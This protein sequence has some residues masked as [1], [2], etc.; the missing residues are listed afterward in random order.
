MADN[1]EAL[2]TAPEID[3]MPEGP[4]AVILVRPQLG[5]NIGMC[6]RAMMNC[7]LSDLRIVDPRDGW[8]N[9][10]ANAAAS[11]ADAIIDNA[12]IFETTE[13]AVA[14]LQF[15]LATTARARDSAQAVYTPREAAPELHRRHQDGVLCG[16]I[17]GPES[18]GL[19]NEDVMQA[20]AIVAAPLN[21]TFKSLNLAQAVF[22]IGYEWLQAGIDETTWRE[23]TSTRESRPATKQELIGLFEH[24][25]QE[26]DDCGFLRPPEKRPAMVRNIRN[27]LHRA[28]FTEQEVR[29]FRGMISGL[30]RRH[31]RN[32][33]DRA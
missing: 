17:F 2:A 9:E 6:A 30:T 31:L 16:V 3:I 4:P 5:E 19:A 29:T 21:P 1:V 10:R 33:K 28:E 18:K 7:G 23:T 27:M 26:L 20:N 12:S 24:L 8:P 13:A 22:C 25:E 11:G 14:D 32:R 15:V